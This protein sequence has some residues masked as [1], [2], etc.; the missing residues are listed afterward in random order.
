M[1]ELFRKI[2]ESNILRIRLLRSTLILSVIVAVVLPFYD[3]VF[4]HPSFTKLLIDDKIDH[5]KAIAKHLSSLIIQKENG[6]SEDSLSH[7]LLNEIVEDNNDFGLVRLNIFST[8]GQVIFS[9]VPEHIGKVVK[10]RYFQEIVAKRELYTNVINKGTK[11]SEGEIIAADSIEIYV[12]CLVGDKFLGAFEF[13]YDIT[14]RKKQLDTLVARSISIEFTIALGLLSIV[15]IVLLKEDK[16]ITQRE[17]AH[18]A[19]RESEAL[20][21]ARGQERLSELRGRPH[22]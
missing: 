1:R 20:N 19:L 5:A 21:R 4:V 7:G 11:S 6:I 10:K 18:Q 14:A 9:T 16:T 12:Q 13:Y 17:Q 3:V 22:R 15:F 2:L 8:S